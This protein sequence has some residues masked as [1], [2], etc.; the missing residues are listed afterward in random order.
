MDYGMEAETPPAALVGMDAHSVSVSLCVTRWR[1][2]WDPAVI[3]EITTDL[4]GLEGTRPPF[5]RSPVVPKKIKNPTFPL[6]FPPNLLLFQSSNVMKIIGTALKSL[7]HL[8]VHSTA[9]A[10]NY[11]EIFWRVNQK[12]HRLS[13]A[14]RRDGFALPCPPFL[15]N[16]NERFTP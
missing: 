5:F 4:K 11:T 3:K 9:R 7:I 13:L 1:R 10:L 12:E 14:A 16:Q 6:Q 8:A 15:T 2:G